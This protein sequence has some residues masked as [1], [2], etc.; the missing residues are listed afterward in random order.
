M[1]TAA[2]LSAITPRRR[3][4][5]RDRES[6]KKIWSSNDDEEKA[7]R[8][9]RER[10]KQFS[11]VKVGGSGCCVVGVESSFPLFCRC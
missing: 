9:K 7:K 11:N 8:K 2:I 6:K 10:E 5:E 4:R 3:E 1:L